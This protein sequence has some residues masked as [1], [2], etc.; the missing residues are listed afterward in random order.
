MSSILLKL[1]IKDFRVFFLVESSRVWTNWLA[2]LT[3]SGVDVVSH[4]I[5]VLL[6]RRERSQSSPLMNIELN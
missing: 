3:Q 4:S 6:I 1:E 5:K 2:K